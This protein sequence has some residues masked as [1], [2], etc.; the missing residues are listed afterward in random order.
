M[1]D[2]DNDA[3]GRKM[4]SVLHILAL[5]SPNHYFGL[6]DKMSKFSKAGKQA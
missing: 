2:F 5:V 1:T 6:G 3:A 4:P